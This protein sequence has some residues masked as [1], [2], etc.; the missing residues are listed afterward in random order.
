MNFSTDN[1]LGS[2]SLA[3]TSHISKAKLQCTAEIGAR[4]N[5]SLTLTELVTVLEEEMS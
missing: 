5:Q 4:G 2:Q 3:H 1:H